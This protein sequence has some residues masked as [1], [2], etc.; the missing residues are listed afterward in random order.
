MGGVQKVT[1]VQILNAGK[2]YDFGNVLKIPATNFQAGKTGYVELVL[3][4]GTAGGGNNQDI[5]AVGGMFS[6]NPSGAQLSSVA[7]LDVLTVKNAKKMLTAV[8][9]A[10]VRVDL[11]RSDLGATMSRMEHVINNLSNIVKNTQEAR[12]RIQDADIAA[13]TTNLTKAQV[14]NQ[15][16]QAMLAQANRTSQSILSLLQ[17]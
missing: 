1:G 8:D 17:T 3:N 11:E 4:G 2:D 13:E 7:M 10:L 16:A 12:S 15:A 14:L 5:T 6:S 9:G